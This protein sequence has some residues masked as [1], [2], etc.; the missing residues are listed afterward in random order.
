MIRLPRLTLLPIVLAL[1]ACS[2]FPA[3]YQTY[4]PGDAPAP[5]PPTNP[6]MVYGATTTTPENRIDLGTPDSTPP[7][8]FTASLAPSSGT[9]QRVAIC[10]SRWWNSAEAVRSAAMQACGSKSAPHIVHQTIDLDACPVMT[11]T[12]AIFACSGAP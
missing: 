7:S 6:M 9:V 12:Q 2:A 8:A 10:Y 4:S 5:A 3:P 1:A 11:P